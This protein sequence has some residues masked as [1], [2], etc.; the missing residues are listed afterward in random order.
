MDREFQAL[1]QSVLVPCTGARAEVPIP[2]PQP[3]P[4]FQPG[5]QLPLV[6]SGSWKESSNPHPQDQLQGES[7]TRCQEPRVLWLL[8]A[9]SLPGLVLAQGQGWMPPASASSLHPQ[10]H[11]VT[12]GSGLASSCHQRSPAK[13][14]RSSVL[15]V[16]PPRGRLTWHPHTSSS[17]APAG[18]A[19]WSRG[20][21]QLSQH[22]NSN[23]SGNP[24]AGFS[25]PRCAGA[26]KG[27]KPGLGREQANATPSHPVSD[28]TG[29]RTAFG[30]STH[31]N[32]WLG[33]ITP[34][35][36]PPPRKRS[37]SHD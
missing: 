26:R 28:K 17:P 6:Y 13:R 18:P 31:F 36:Q 35:T 1:P 22:G 23:Q 10:C 11:P 30:L 9:A 3:L 27:Q 20:P 25:R 21:G 37:Q 34:P 8:V 15:R 5:L 2:C 16:L 19:P 4:Q 24:W 32:L 29:T 12:L 33:V 14:S 7:S